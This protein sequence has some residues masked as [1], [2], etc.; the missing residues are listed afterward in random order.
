M[1]VNISHQENAPKP[2]VFSV[3]GNVIEVKLLQEYH[4]P[5]ILYA[6][7]IANAF[8]PIL[9]KPSGKTKLAKP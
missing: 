6:P 3:L 5:Y 7:H 4:S 1:L 8:L 9:V 2:M